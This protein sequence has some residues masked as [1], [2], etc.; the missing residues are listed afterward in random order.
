MYIRR[1][2]TY[3]SPQSSGPAREYNVSPSKGEFSGSAGAH[4][5]QVST[6]LPDAAE[7]KGFTVE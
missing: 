5:N 4:A 2:T 7:V 6:L 3:T 1:I